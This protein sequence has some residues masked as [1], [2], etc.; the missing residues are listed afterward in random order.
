MDKL[1]QFAVILVE[2]NGVGMSPQTIKTVFNPFMQVDASLDRSNGGLGL[3]LAIVKGLVELHGGTVKA[4]SNG[5]GKGS[6][7]TECLPLSGGPIPLEADVSSLTN[8]QHRQRV[9]LIEDI[10]DVAE[11]LRLLLIE[12]GHDVMV[13]HDGINGVDLAKAYRPNVIICGI[14]LPGMDGYQVARSL[15]ADAELQN[16]FLI[17]LSGYARSE[18]LQRAKE[19]GFHYQLAKPVGLDALRQAFA[20]ASI[21]GNTENLT[22]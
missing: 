20:Q 14:G 12:E 6:V 16:T 11:V 22:A 2:D 19:A 5:L 4:C 21:R 15:R 18:D 1:K 17:S 13:A 8:P 7:F 3:G 10:K 9:L